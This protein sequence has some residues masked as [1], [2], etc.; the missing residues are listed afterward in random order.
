MHYTS[1]F[2]N[3]LVSNLLVAVAGLDL[4]ILQLRL[5]TGLQ[6]YATMLDFFRSLYEGAVLNVKKLRLMSL[7]PFS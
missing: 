7:W 3:K 1:L 4:F 5:L 6:N 2:E